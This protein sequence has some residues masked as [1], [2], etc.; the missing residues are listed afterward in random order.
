[1]EEE[2]YLPDYSIVSA[3]EKCENIIF[4]AK[5]KVDIEVHGDDDC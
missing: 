2:N 1:M 4:I 3:G 5:G